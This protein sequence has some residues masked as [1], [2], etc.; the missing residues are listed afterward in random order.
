[1]P[2]K[3][4]RWRA[5]EHLT[6]LGAPAVYH[7]LIEV[8]DGNDLDAVLARYRRLDAHILHA[9]GGDVFPASPIY[10]VNST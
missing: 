1:M 10:A 2:H 4:T 8:A 3:I 9:L 7:C 6:D 5:V